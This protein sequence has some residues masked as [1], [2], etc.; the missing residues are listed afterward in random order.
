MRNLLQHYYRLDLPEAVVFGLGAGLDFYLLPMESPMLSGRSVSLEQDAA[1]HLGIDYEE[2]IEPDNARAWEAVK[3]EILADRPVM[4]T[5]DIFYLDYREFKVHFPAHR[6]V[7]TGFDDAAGEAYIMDRIH[8]AVETCSLEALA[9][10]RNPPRGISTFNLWGRFDG[11]F[12]AID[13]D[14]LRTACKRA[15][16]VNAARMNGSMENHSLLMTGLK[17]QYDLETGIR[18]LRSLPAEISSWR[19]R[20]QAGRILAFN[21]DCIEKFGTGGGLFRNLYTDFLK[22]VSE[23]YPD[24]AGSGEVDLCRRAASLWTD[25]GG[26]FRM[27]SEDSGRNDLWNTATELAEAIGQTEERLFSSIEKRMAGG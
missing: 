17:M 10:S 22:Y 5:G 6:F 3:Q 27:L 7:L 24:L 11:P 19:S 18:A 20:E 21:A 9:K 8:P 14:R 12:S 15:L 26:N 1:R 4:L 25:L 16:E 13:K 2:N 23:T